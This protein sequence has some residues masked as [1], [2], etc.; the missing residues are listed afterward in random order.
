MH[1]LH[2]T[3][4]MNQGGTER[5]IINLISQSL[6]NGYKISLVSPQG[7]GL[8]KVPEDVDVY[9][10]RNWVAIRPFSAT[11]ELKKVLLSI[12][13]K[14]DI[15]QI[16]AAAEMVYLARKFLPK[17]PIIFNCH[18][19]DNALPSYFN[20][21][22]AARFL[23]KVTRLIVLN[24]LDG[25][26]FSRAGLRK[27]KL[28]FIPNGVEER[29][30]SP[31]SQQKDNRKIVGIV[32]RLVKQKN[33]GWAIKAQAKY[34][35]A[36]KLLIVG[37]GPLRSKLERGANKLK[38]DGEVQFLGHREKMEDIYPLFS[39]LLVCSRNEAC[40]LV[41]LEALA[42]GTYVFIPNWLPG[43][44]KLWR[45]S[46][47]VFVFKDAEDI[48]RQIEKKKEENELE[49]IQ[50]FARTFLWECIFKRYK[51]LYSEVLGRE[52]L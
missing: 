33:I 45:S 43:L 21:W 10:L 13:K 24:P 12:D 3:P 32:G 37:D 40:P 41:V 2:L 46:P 35:F 47:G 14:V 19:Y 28:V 50:G 11:S 42:S 36:S 18:G 20:Y 34:K 25:E 5:C 16:H 52:S 15:I 48:K 29:F 27:E 44:V 39:Y 4:Y 22:L 1:I 17:K 31:F 38:L 7:E 30:F 8:K 23:K 6:K 26:Y 9:K 49:E 51:K